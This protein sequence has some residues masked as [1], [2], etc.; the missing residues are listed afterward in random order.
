MLEGH[1]STLDLL[2]SKIKVFY[3]PKERLSFAHC[4]T[5]ALAISRRE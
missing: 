2:N 1:V 4:E 5:F 3:D